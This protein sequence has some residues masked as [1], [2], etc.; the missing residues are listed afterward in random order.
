MAIFVHNEP[1]CLA[2]IQ[3]AGLPQVFY[4][5]IEIGLEPMIEVDTRA[6]RIHV[7][8]THP[9]SQ[10]IQAVPN[11]LGA[12]CLNQEGQNQL[13]SRPSIIPGLLSI[14][15]SERHL[16]VLADKEN[17]VMMGTA[18]DELIRHHPSLKM[19]VLSSLKATLSKIEEMG[20]SYVPEK[21]HLVWYALLPTPAVGA[22]GPQVEGAQAEDIM[23]EE[24]EAPVVAAEVGVATPA[25]ADEETKEDQATSS[26]TN[27]IVSFIDVLGRVSPFS[28]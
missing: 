9:G 18:V 13:A 27:S 20:N 21:E 10:V 6:T 17:A 3:E 1:T 16:K 23:M 11:A 28:P 22:E 12:L 7:I 26:P 8:V 5:A 24:L 15:T 25:A 19:S 14:F 2:V 4:Q